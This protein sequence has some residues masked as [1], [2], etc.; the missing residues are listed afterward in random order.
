M[1]LKKLIK[2]NR[3]DILSSAI[4][5]PV[6]AIPMFLFVFVIILPTVDLLV[7]IDS[8]VVDAMIV[9]AEELGLEKH[10]I[11]FFLLS[12]LG[13]TLIGWYFALM[14]CFWIGEWIA[15]RLLKVLG[16][17][18]IGMIGVEKKKEKKE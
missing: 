12:I 18:T 6:V 5:F 4:A 2:D 13:A 15:N 10:H 16:L 3:D 9:S 17:K 11:L 14:L 1:N 8:N 7:I